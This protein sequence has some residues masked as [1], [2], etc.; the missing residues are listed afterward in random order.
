[1]AH[2]LSDGT[3]KTSNELLNEY[4]LSGFHHLLETQSFFC[5]KLGYVAGRFECRS[6]SE[7][8]AIRKRYRGLLLA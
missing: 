1:M 5:V 3:L 8:S 4:M 6:T 2:P 7:I